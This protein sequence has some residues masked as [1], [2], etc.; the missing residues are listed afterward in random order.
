MTDALVV[1]GASGFIGRNFVRRMT[2]RVGELVAVVGSSGPVPEADRTIRLTELDDLPALPA[3]T[4]VVHLAAQRYDAARFEMAQSD[5]VTSNVDIANRV[6]RFCLKRGLKEVRM[7]STVAVYPAAL[8]QLDDDVPV[9]LNAPPNAN[10]AFYAWAKRWAEIAAKLHR[11]RFGINTIS[12]RL[13]NPYGPFDSTDLASAHVLPAFV[14]RALSDAPV[15]EIKGNPLVERDFTFVDDVVEVF[16]RSLALRGVSKALNLCRGETTTLLDL[17]Q[18]V[19]NVA[20]DRRPIQAADTVTHGVLA[21]RSTNHGV[22]E[23]F[24]KQTFASLEDGLR[25]TIDWYRHARG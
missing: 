6:F 5:L 20:G 16:E 22:R 17:A 19:L 25:P 9:D 23:M 2:G 12:F 10:E 13:S 1:V 8:D 11:D 7:A 14:M 24:G 18:T 4:V 21:R 15:F 3:D